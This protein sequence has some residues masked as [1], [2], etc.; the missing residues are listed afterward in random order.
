[1]MTHRW[2]RGHGGVFFRN[3]GHPAMEEL[4]N[5][6][7]IEELGKGELCDSIVALRV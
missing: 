3:K 1:M 2:K 6:P 4:I 5:A 7:P